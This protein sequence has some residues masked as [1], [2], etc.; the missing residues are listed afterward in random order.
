MHVQDIAGSC[1][2]IQACSIVNGIGGAKVVKEV[3]INTQFR[4]INENDY[5]NHIMVLKCLW[6]KT[7]LKKQFVTTL[8]ISIL[9][10]LSILR[11]CH[12][13]RRRGAVIDFNAQVCE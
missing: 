5:T 6:R 11:Q 7:K 10:K 1:Y 12:G 2:V 4:D 8:L 9:P 3:S 13:P